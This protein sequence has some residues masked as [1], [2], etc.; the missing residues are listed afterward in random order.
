MNIRQATEADY[1]A[2]RSFV[3]RYND[4][5]WQR[6]FPPPPLPDEWLREGRLLVA[7]SDDDIVGMARGELRQGL[8]RV[9]LVYVIGDRRRQ[10]IAS[11]LLRELLGFFREHGIEHVSLGVDT[12]NDEALTVWRR[13][14]FVEY[15]RELTTSL[16]ALERRLGEEARGVSFG[17]V[18]LQTDDQGAVAQALERFVP[19]LFRSPATVVS[20]PRNGW[21]GVYNE[22]ASREPERLRRLA[23]ELSHITGGVV[24][25]LGVEEDAVLR[26]LAFERGRLMDEYL[27]QPEHYGP[28]PPGDAVALR[29]NPRVLARLTGGDMEAIRRVAPGSGAD[30][31]PP[32]EQLR[33]LADVL[34]IEGA[35]LDAREAAGRQG[36]MTVEHP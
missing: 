3:E 19:R 4:E 20:A 29:I 11:A 6:P 27:S 34:G 7:E 16:P 8:G 28:L 1:T 23:Q 10:G 21:V 17:S 36:A 12:T 33:R 18:H 25:A 2:V 31:P 32:L 15:Q 24:L 35:G 9:N 14:G 22:V 30:L 13:L 5:F 26:S